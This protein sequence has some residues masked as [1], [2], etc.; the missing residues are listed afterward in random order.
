MYYTLGQRKGL[1]I[2][3]RQHA[4]EAPWYVVDKDL[5]NNILIVAQGQHHPHLYHNTLET[6]HIHWINGVDSAADECTAKI[7]YRQP[8]QQC[9]IESTAE[10]RH[11]VH[12]EQPQRAITPGQSI[13]FYQDEVCLGGGVI[14]NMRNS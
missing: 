12:F 1:G 4:D 13:V 8:D 2:G 9:S 10:D 5:V 3:G 7:R 14:E 6:G 11:I